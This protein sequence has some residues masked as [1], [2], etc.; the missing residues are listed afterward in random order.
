MYYIYFCLERNWG[1]VYL[2]ASQITNGMLI[3]HP[4]QNNVVAPIALLPQVPKFP[5]GHAYGG[6]KILF[7]LGC[8][9]SRHNMPDRGQSKAVTARGCPQVEGP[10]VGPRGTTRTSNFCRSRQ[11]VSRP[12]KVSRICQFN[13][14]S[15]RPA[16]KMATRTRMR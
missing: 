16:P 1:A 12:F 11:R 13:C 3:E 9:A 15:G 7:D 6:H 2:I 10:V 14:V 8:P 5:R 4:A